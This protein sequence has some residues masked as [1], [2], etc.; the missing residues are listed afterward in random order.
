MSTFLHPVGPL[1]ARV[2]WLRRLAVLG[3][4]AAVIFT[5]NAFVNPPKS[6]TPTASPT[7]TATDTPVAEVTTCD[8]AVIT[9]DAVTDLE[10]YATTEKPQFSMTITNTGDVACILSVG[11]DVQRYVVVSGSET[12]WDSTVCQK[13]EEALELE[14]AAGEAKTTA[15]LE[16]SRNRSDA[17][18]TDATP[19]VGGGASYHL[20][21]FLGDIESTKSQQFMLF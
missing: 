3:V 11:T 18:D 1:P 12:I 9:V 4:I 15:T 7:E 13:S 5:V 17:C 10:S 21:V 6:A 8:P 16:W 19:A 14:F 2:Y 20:S